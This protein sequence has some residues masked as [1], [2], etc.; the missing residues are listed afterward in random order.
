M[1]ALKRAFQALDDRVHAWETTLSVGFF[2]A[3]RQIR[4]TSVWTTA[5]IVLVMVL[6]FLNLVV[7]TGILVGLIQGSVEAVQTHYLGNVFISTL[8]DRPYIDQSPALILA[9]SRVPGVTSL[10]ARYI[11]GGSVASNYK[12]LKRRQSDIDDR[13]GTSIV[14]IDPVAEEATTHLSSLLVE[15][16]YLEP[17]DYDQVIVGAM[18][19]KQYIDF[20]SANFPVLD[21]V[22]IGSRIKVTVGGNEREVTVKG[23]VKS[24]VDEIDRRV[25]F[26]DSQL[27]SLIQRSDYNVDEVSVALAPGTDPKTVKQTILAQGFGA[28]AKV[29]T[30]EDAEPKFIKDMRETFAML[31]NIIGSV[32]IV[33]ASIT[34][35]I[36]IFINAITRKKFIGILKGIGISGASIETSYVIQSIFY[37]VL[38]A[39]I[40]LVLLYGFLEPYLRQNPIDFPFG[41]GILV[42]PLGGTLF[43]IGI[44]LVM[45]IIAGYVPA[46]LVVKKHTLDAILGR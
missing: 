18:L 27:R 4:R 3:F 39:A 46:R 23:I 7:V 25:F 19:L 12:Q 36:V 14:G 44:I 16:S 9:V 20:E 26:V 6:T 13:V 17:G 2:L 1:K 10:S 38:G 8:K 40:G 34:I 21:G 24:K 43:R 15:G 37:A 30:Q 11:E 32:G 35:F 42:A 33:A 22:S 29:Q 41:D 45:T 28:Y 5:L 31:G